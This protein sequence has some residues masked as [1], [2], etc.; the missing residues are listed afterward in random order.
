MAKVDITVEVCGMAGDGTIAA[1]G[2]LN[3]AMSLGG[4]A[5]LGFDSYPAEIRGFGRCVTRSRIGTDEIVALEDETHVL[6]SLD[7]EQSISRVPSLAREAAVFI[8]SKPPVYRDESQ[9]LAA[10]VEPGTMLYAM[11]FTD[12]AVAASGT[13]RGR[14]LAALGGF[15]AVFG[16]AKGLFRDVITRKFKAKGDKVLGANLSSFDAGFDYAMAQFADRLGLLFVL[17]QPLDGP[18]KIMMSGNEAIGKA[19][20]DAGVKLYFG[21][22]ITPATPIMEFLARHLPDRGGRVVQMEDEISS[23][24]AV[25]GSFYAGTRAMTATSGPGFALMTELLG[26][27]VMAEIP[28]VILNA[29]RGGPS[30][31]LPTKTEQSDLHAA[32]FGGPGDSC[33]IVVAPTNVAEC[34]ELTVKSFQWAEKYQ[35]PVIVLTDF[36]LDNRV[37]NL[38]LPVASE[39]DKAHGNV[40][41]DARDLVPYR[42][43]ALTESGISPRSVPGMEGFICPATGLEHLETGIPD[44][45]PENHMKMSAKRHRKIYG[46]LESLPAP[47]E[48]SSGGPLDVGVIG[49]GSTFGSVLEAVRIGQEKGLKVGALKIMTLFPFHAGHIREFMKKCEHILIPELNYQ[50]QLANLIGSLALKDVVRLNKVTGTPFPP[51]EILMRMEALAHAGVA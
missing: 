51:S 31:G 34:Y 45:S 27:G 10:Q 24:G 16:A 42:R 12:L 28:A 4:F 40:F 30:T 50:G 29:Q 19:A 15:A 35:T 32:V 13:P 14:N 17:S 11:P 23:I 3:E 6:I 38:P 25:L 9:S 2:L 26:H 21:Y 33:R 46:A 49:W 22:P 47:V 8:D 39:E 18:Q 41:P 7:D 43:Y 20:L 5:V 44:Y 37:E 48:F 36:Y 1:G